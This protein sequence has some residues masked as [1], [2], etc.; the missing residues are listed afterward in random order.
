MVH[1]R[2][3]RID[4]NSGAGGVSVE[5]TV[6]AL[7]VP[8]LAYTPMFSSSLPPT[9]MSLSPV[10]AHNFQCASAVLCNLE[11]FLSPE[12]TPACQGIV[13]SRHTLPQA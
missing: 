13:Q 2:L 10:V 12:E 8:S 5:A 1:R 9:G 3:P 7:P 6:Y 4:Y 11:K